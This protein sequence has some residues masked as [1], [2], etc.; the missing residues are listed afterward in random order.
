MTD[1]VMIIVQLRLVKGI[2]AFQLDT[3]LAGYSSDEVFQTLSRYIHQSVVHQRMNG[4]QAGVLLQI[5]ECR[6]NFTKAV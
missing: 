1:D 3:S 6:S 4:F 2:A 5:S